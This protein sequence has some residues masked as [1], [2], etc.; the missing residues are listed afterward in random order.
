[1]EIFLVFPDKPTTSTREGY[2]P[3]YIFPSVVYKD[4]A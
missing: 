4:R 3:V 2:P 1:M